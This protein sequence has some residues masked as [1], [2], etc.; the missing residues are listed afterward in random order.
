M[1]GSK[2]YKLSTIIDHERSNMHVRAVGITKSK[3]QALTQTTTA[4]KTVIALKEHTRKDLEYKFRNIHA[5][6]KK[7][8]PISDVKWLNQ[9]DRAKGIDHSTTYDNTTAA[10]RFIEFISTT[11][12]EKL[13]DILSKMKFF[14][15]NNGWKH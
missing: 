11:E 2:N 6:I 15:S 10:T 13:N 3:E 7:N 5:L 4:H 9:L 8:R 1:V 12:K 14:F